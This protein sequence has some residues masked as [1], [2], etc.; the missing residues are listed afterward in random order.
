MVRVR[1]EPCLY[2]AATLRRQFVID[3]GVQLV[4]GDGNLWGGHGRCLCLILIKIVCRPVA[5]S[6]SPPRGGKNR[7]HS[8]LF[9]ASTCIMLAIISPAAAPGA[10]PRAR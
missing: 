4:F 6:P 7:R 1:W 9:I 10:R 5:V 8:N 2:I 3:V